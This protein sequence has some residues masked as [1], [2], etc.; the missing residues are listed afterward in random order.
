MT[1]DNITAAINALGQVAHVLADPVVA[2]T[3]VA[4]TAMLVVAYVVTKR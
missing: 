4:T 1:P 2:I 3:F